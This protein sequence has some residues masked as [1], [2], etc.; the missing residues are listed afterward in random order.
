MNTSEASLNL[1][2][3]APPQRLPEPLLEELL[4]R[5]RQDERPGIVDADAVGANARVGEIL[6]AEQFQ[7]ART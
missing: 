5:I 7:V 1:H 6:I 2:V 4:L 3:A